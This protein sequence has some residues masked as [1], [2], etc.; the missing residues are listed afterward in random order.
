MIK[1]IIDK[2]KDCAYE[3]WQVIMVI[4][5]VSIIGA[6]ACRYKDIKEQG[7]QEFKIA[8]RIEINES[9]GKYIIYYSD[10][11]VEDYYFIP[12]CIKLNK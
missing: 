8:D 3:N 6:S 5:I 10:G 1:R 7:C 4:L 12:S 2:I 11:R 9:N